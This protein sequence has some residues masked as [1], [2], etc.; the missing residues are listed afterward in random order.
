MKGFFIAYTNLQS[1]RFSRINKSLG[2]M[3]QER[4]EEAVQSP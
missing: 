2:L 3:V 1:G 4:T